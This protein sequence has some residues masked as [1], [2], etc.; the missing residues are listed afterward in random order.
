MK[1][2]LFTLL[3]AIMANGGTIWGIVIGDLAYYLDPDTKTAQVGDNQYVSGDIVIPASVVNPYDNT[4]YSVTSIMYQAF[5]YNKNLTSI[6]IPNSITNIGMRAFYY[7]NN[8]ASVS[9]GT[10]VASIEEGAFGGCRSLTSITI[11]NSVTTI[12][13]SAF[14]GC[15]LTTVEL[16][17]SITNI[18]YGAFEGCLALESIEIPNSV[19]IIE[20]FA[21]NSC[22]SLN[23]LT[24]PENV[25]SIGSAAFDNCS[26]LTSLVIGRCV[27]NIGTGAFADCSKLTSVTINSNTIVGGTYG[28]TS[29][30]NIGAIFGTQVTDYI[31]G[32]GVTSIGQY[33]FYSCNKMKTIT[34]PSTM[35]TINGGA[36]SG[37]SGLK[38]VYISDLTAWCAVTYNA[39]SPYYTQPMYYASNLYLNGELVTDLQI[40]NSVTNINNYAFY[41]SKCITSVTFPENLATIGSNAFTGCSSLISVEFPSGISVIGGGAF[42]QC[43][44]IEDIIIPES[45]DSIGPNAFYSCNAM[46]NVIFNATNPPIVGD[47]CFDSTPTFSVPCGTKA[48]Y[49]AALAV[50]ASRVK[51]NCAHSDSIVIPQDSVLNFDDLTTDTVPQIIIEPQGEITVNLADIRIGD[52][53]ITSDGVHSGQVHGGNNLHAQHVYMEYILNSLGTTASPDRWYAFAV[54]FEVDIATGISRTC[55]NKTL[56]SGTDF[57]ILEYNGLLRAL[58]GKGWSQ[59]LTGTL[60]PGNFYMLGID[61]NC[62]H[63]RFEKKEGQPVQGN[64]NQSFAANGAGDPAHS[65]QN[66]G[67]NGMGNTQLEYSSIDLSSYGMEYLVTYDNKHGK[68]VTRRIDEID[69]FVGQP[70]FIQAPGDGSFDFHNNAHPHPVPALRAQKAANPSLHFTLTNESGNVGTDHLYLTMH[71]DITGTYTIGRDITL[72]SSNCTTAAQLWCT[73]SDGTQLSAHGLAVPASETTVNISLYVPTNGEY[74]LEMNTRAMEEFDIELL[75]QGEHV[76]NL[77][78]NQ[79]LTLSLNAGITDYMLRIS[80]KS[81]TDLSNVPSDDVQSTKKLIDNKLYI[82]Q[83]RH[84]Y[85]AQGKKVK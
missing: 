14:S 80:R 66:T 54:P 73:N 47:Y 19:G 30:S 55:D 82:F 75:Y 34:I 36:F 64:N 45:V 42:L 44:A 59:K 3:F 27:T 20:D 48:A 79:A 11:P 69:L 43:R 37:C 21:F 4:M 41:G 9:I 76:A 81:P 23:S 1:Q 35:T 12:G 62:N 52:V 51:D 77:F 5:A 16:P 22:I 46:T 85:D 70:F 49:V 26:N 10:G 17:N 84:I 13:R 83:G 28:G 53:I 6:T 7:C 25:T 65:P 78:A 68:Y 40:P 58:Q 29:S 61:G 71:D 32:E 63:W 24:I 67:W 39:T 8:L 72:M 15:G 57:L 56:V 33:A 50:D 38:S 60:E 74:L 18:S 2:K 31:I